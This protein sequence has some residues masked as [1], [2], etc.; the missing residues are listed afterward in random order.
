VL[1]SATVT[2][3]AV[4]LMCN[5]L[6]FGCGAAHVLV[7]AVYCSLLTGIGSL[8]TGNFQSSL[9]TFDDCHSSSSEGGNCFRSNASSGTGS[10][11]GATAVD[12][13]VASSSIAS[14]DV[15]FIVALALRDVDH[16]KSRLQGEVTD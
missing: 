6:C 12:H 3:S 14:V 2:N 7:A 15:T 10:F 11:G 13:M 9:W 4:I 1:V 8:Y 5:L 16:M